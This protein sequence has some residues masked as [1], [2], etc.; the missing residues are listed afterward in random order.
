MVGPDSAYAKFLT[1]VLRG[2]HD[3]GWGGGDPD[4]SPGSVKTANN[5][6]AGP[7]IFFRLAGS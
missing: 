3:L 6:V 7:L 5:G 1:E 2:R 4:A